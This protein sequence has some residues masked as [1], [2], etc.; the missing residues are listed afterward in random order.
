MDIVMH[1]V[2][3]FTDPA[4]W[5]GPDGVPIRLIEHIQLAGLAVVAGAAIGLPAGL[6]IGHSGRGAFAVTNIANLGR[7]LPSFA[8]LVMLIPFAVDLGLDFSF[9]P[10]LAAMVLLATFLV[11]NAMDLVYLL[12]FLVLNAVAFL[13]ITAPS[14]PPGRAARSPA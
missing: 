11:R 5:H 12:P 7:A 1:V 8:L 13:G 6:A 9:W 14:S 4:H 10:V 3:W 2:A